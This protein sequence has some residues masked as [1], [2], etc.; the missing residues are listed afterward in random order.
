MLR[1]AAD[2]K[3]MH[4][5]SRSS[6]INAKLKSDKWKNSRNLKMNEKYWIMSA[7]TH[8]APRTTNASMFSVSISRALLSSCM[9]SKHRP[10]LKWSTPSVTLQRREFEQDY[11]QLN[12]SVNLQII[13]EYRQINIGCWFISSSTNFDKHCSLK[14]NPITIFRRL[15]EVIYCE[16]Y[17]SIIF[18]FYT[19]MHLYSK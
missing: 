17:L 16:S 13:P 6:E 11:Y 1:K 2:N 12:T 19:F 18:Y 10:C 7:E 14:Y 15:T 8:S 4:I 3:Y 5:F 9:A